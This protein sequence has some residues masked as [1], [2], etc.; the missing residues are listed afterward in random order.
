[1][2]TSVKLDAELKER[3]QNLAEA[4]Q[5]S[6]HWIM[7]EAIRHYVT[8]EEKKEAFKQDALDAWSNYQENGMHLTHEEADEWLQKLESGENAEIPKCHD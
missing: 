7:C 2:A 8:C 3:V 1:M 4:R 5:R 6:A